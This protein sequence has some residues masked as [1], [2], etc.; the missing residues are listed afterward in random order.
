[1]TSSAGGVHGARGLAVELALVAV[2]MRD[3]LLDLAPAPEQVR[4]SG[5][6]RET[7]AEAE[8]DPRR[9]PVAII[10]DG[11]P[12]G[13]FVLDEAGHPSVAASGGVLLRAFF[14]DARW[15][16]RG[17]AKSAVQM[18]P[19]FVR[20]HLPGAP[21]VVLTVNARNTPA[22]RA[23]LSGGFEDTGQLDHSGPL[24]PQHVLRLTV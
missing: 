16:R 10:A 5:T 13:L 21:C 17:V 2:D 15:Q 8:R 18:L 1:M 20:S 23:Y 22:L 24:G 9:R 14:V 12:V 4:F 7:L 19:A 3:A 11:R 6:A